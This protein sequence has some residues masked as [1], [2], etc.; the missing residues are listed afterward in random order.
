VSII[1]A[2]DASV[3]SE[4][5]SL[6]AGLVAGTLD[7]YEAARKMHG[8]G[9]RNARLADGR[10]DYEA[11]AH[12]LIWGALTDWIENR[13]EEQ[14]QAEEAIIDA[15]RDWLAVE[16]DPE[17]TLAYFDR[18]IYDVCGYSRRE[19]TQAETPPANPSA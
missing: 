5:R 6:C 7:P 13:P 9:M 16:D 18:M 1:K 15:A 8:V 19:S 2:V 4:L 3:R 17:A 14:P 10:A 12:W 11:W